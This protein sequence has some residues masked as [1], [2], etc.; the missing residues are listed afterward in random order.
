MVTEGSYR[1]IILQVVNHFPYLLGV[2]SIERELLLK[3]N[4]FGLP[5]SLS[6]IISHLPE[7]EPV[8]LIMHVPSLSP[9]AIL[10]VE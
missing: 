2:R 5:D 8:S 10:E 7:R 4:N 6:A 9:N 1:G 3:V